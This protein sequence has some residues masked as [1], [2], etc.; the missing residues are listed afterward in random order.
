MKLTGCV[1]FVATASGLIY[2]V[3]VMVVEVEVPPELLRPPPLD[4]P[5]LPPAAALPSRR[6]TVLRVF[7]RIP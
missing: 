5:D 4:L 6:K 2:V 1:L 3:V 7:D